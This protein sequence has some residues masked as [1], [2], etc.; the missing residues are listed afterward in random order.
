MS[1]KLIQLIQIVCAPKVGSDLAEFQFLLTVDRRLG[2]DHVAIAGM[3]SGD[4][5]VF[6]MGINPNP[7]ARSDY[8]RQDATNPVP[9]HADKLP[10]FSNGNKVA[11]DGPLRILTS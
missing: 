1:M 11:A 8:R 9:S 10:H 4:D 2:V 5:Q 6:P 3:F 7:S